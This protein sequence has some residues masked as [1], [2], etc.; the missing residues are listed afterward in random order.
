MGSVTSPTSFE[1]WVQ[2]SNT[3]GLVTL[4]KMFNY[5]EPYVPYPSMRY[6]YDTYLHPRLWGLTAWVCTFL[7][8]T[9]W[10][11]DFDKTHLNCLCCHFI[12]H[13]MIIAHV[14]HRI[15]KD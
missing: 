9:F 12:I 6:S 3:D 11:R 1:T 15:I 8:A 14:H 13:K 5:L 2:I 7:S 10:L 4:G